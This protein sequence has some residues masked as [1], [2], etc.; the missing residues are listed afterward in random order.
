MGKEKRRWTETFT[1][2]TPFIQLYDSGPAFVEYV[3]RDGCAQCIEVPLLPVHEG[4][5][6]AMGTAR[7][8]SFDRPACG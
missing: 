2:D 4:A 6:H 5:G 1:G 3:N 7:T 8:G